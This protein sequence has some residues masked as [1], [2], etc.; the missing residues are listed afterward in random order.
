[1]SQK[2]LVLSSSLFP[3]YS[4]DS[5]THNQLKNQTK[6]L[7]PHQISTPT[8]HASTNQR[9][10]RPQ[11]SPMIEIWKTIMDSPLQRPVWARSEIHSCPR[12][13][14]LPFK[15]SNNPTGPL[16]LCKNPSPQATPNPSIFLHASRSQPVHRPQKPRG[17]KKGM[18]VLRRPLG[19]IRI[20]LPPLLLLSG[21]Y[22]EQKDTLQLC[23][24]PALHH[25]QRLQHQASSYTG[26]RVEF[27]WHHFAGQLS[28]FTPLK[29]IQTSTNQKRI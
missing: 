21:V 15:S 5:P 24:S 20:L 9:F 18:P 14:P 27:S 1:V 3:S 13:P 23:T 11:S 8:H 19:E 2:D 22:A 25:T 17:C 10:E 28:R 26:K 16:T 6:S 12:P 4:G 29:H 7:K